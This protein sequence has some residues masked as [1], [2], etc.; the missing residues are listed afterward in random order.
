M[1]RSRDL[2][3]AHVGDPAAPRF[4]TSAPVA[5]SAGPDRVRLRI[6]IQASRR[7]T[8][9]KSCNFFQKKL[10][11]P[12]HRIIIHFVPLD[13]DFGDWAT[14]KESK[15]GHFLRRS[16]SPPSRMPAPLTMLLN[17]NDVPLQPLAL[18]TEWLQAAAA[19]HLPEPGAMTLATATADGA[20]S[21]RMVLLRGFD[22]RGLVFYT[23]YRSRKAAELD[24]NPNAALV[25]FWASLHRQIRVEGT[26]EKV[27]AAE[28]DTYFHSRPRSSRLGAIASPQSAVIAGR[29]VL[30][31][32]LAELLRC[33][34]TARCHA[35]PTGAA[36]GSCRQCSSSGRDATAG[37][38]I[39]SAI[40]GRMAP[41]LSSGSA[42]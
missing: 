15:A 35:H 14:P 40:A 29:H 20:P 34:P 4:V 21:A 23:N 1:R 38:T 28:S 9:S 13:D 5:A 33:T 2:E 22:E 41:G 31:D 16:S 30:D 18:F 24:A 32:R 36:T 27:S 6:G 10:E 17:E 19:A 3:R 42:P 7:I 37:C 25:L 26:V 39:A 8:R 12:V 11:T